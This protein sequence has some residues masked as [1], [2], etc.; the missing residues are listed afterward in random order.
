MKRKQH[1]R[2]KRYGLVAVILVVILGVG[3]IYSI[4]QRT[5][6]TK[7]TTAVSQSSKK[8]HHSSQSTKSSRR[9]Q[10]SA[11]PKSTSATSSSVVKRTG[12]DHVTGVAKALDS[13]S[14]ASLTQV[15][16]QTMNNVAASNHGPARWTVAVKSLDGKQHAYV[17]DWTPANAQFSASAIKLFILIRYYQLLN[18]HQLNAQDTYTLRKADVVEGSGV[19]LNAPIG[20]VYTLQKLVQLMV[21]KSDNIATNVLI[22][23]VGGFAGVNQTISGLVGPNHE[24]SL[25][26]KMMDTSNIENGKANRINAEEVVDTLLKLYQGK[27]VSRSADNQMLNYMTQTLNRTKLP[28]Q[29]PTGAICYNKSGESSYRGIENDEAIIVYQGH[30][31]AVCALTEM[32]GD[33]ETPLTAT[34]V[35]TNS[36]VSSIAA[37]GA[38]LTKW[39]VTNGN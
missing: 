11:S 28:S 16:A 12:P 17:S 1:R 22:D 29:L 4:T 5:E 9:S 38:N 19:M 15:I 8:N 21:E 7:E 23:K 39:F 35:Q 26:R 20:T 30:V 18:Q 31:F 2:N 37:L 36:Q 27:I 24:S 14:N 10:S 13:S 34:N 33:G 32:D 25:E 3:L 6:A